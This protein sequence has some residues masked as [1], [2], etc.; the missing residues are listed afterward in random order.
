MSHRIHVNF[1]FSEHRLLGSR[2]AH[3]HT[4]THRA[5]RCKTDYESAIHSVL[6]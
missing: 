3:T 5:R 6:G 1:S 4:N 2:Y